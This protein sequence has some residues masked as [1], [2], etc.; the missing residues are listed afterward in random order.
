MVLVRDRPTVPPGP[1]LSDSREAGV[2][3]DA[4]SRQRL[5][6][7]T[8]AALFLALALMAVVYLS[9]GG[10]GRSGGDR[11]PVS[12]DGASFIQTSTLR[13][14]RG[15]TTSTF[16]VKGI[17]G[18]AFDARFDAPVTAAFAVTT[19]IGPPPDLGF[20]TFH[21]LTDRHDCRVVA[22]EVLCVVHFAAGGT[23]GGTWRWTVAKTS[24][25][26]AVVHISVAFNSH[27]GDYP[28]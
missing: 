27:T 15:R 10:G 21:T 12:H 2:I 19:N 23:P 26:A 4:R 1:L 25:P 22:A 28:G 6:R 8:G 5:H 24:N 3:D 11:P 13:L 16:L 18:H 20:P 14:P 7:R 9:A 17:A